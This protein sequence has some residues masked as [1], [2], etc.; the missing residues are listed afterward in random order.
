MFKEWEAIAKAV[1]MPVLGT[2]EGGGRGKAMEEIC[3]AVMTE[4]FP[5][6][7]VRR[8]TTDPGSSETSSKINTKQNL[9]NHF[10]AR[11]I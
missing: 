11:Y 4:S 1:H 2:A 8:Q 7:N 9:K 5:H 6:V 3:E 10:E